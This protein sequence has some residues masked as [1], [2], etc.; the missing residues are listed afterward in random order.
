MHVAKAPAQKRWK[1]LRKR[2]RIIRDFK[3]NKYIY[4]MAVPVLLY[5][6]VIHYIP[7][8]GAVIA[9][10]DFSPVKG[11]SGSPWV[12]WKHFSNFYD[13]YYFWR[14]IRNTFLINVYQLLF[15]FPA[16]IIFALMLN[17][18][19]RQWFKR[20]VQTVTY[21]PHFISIIVVCGM[22]VDFLA[23]DGF[24]THVLVWFGLE[25]TA[26]LSKAEYFR[27]IYIASDIWQHIGWGSII[28]L[29]ALSGINPELYEASKV[30]GAGRF[31]Q[32]VHVTI[33]GI[34]PMIVILLI[35][36]I[37][38][39]MELG[40]EKI[41][42]LYNPN[43]YET[44]DVLASFI[45]RRGL[46]SGSEYSYTTAIGLFQSMIN[47]MLLVMANYISRRLN[48]TSLW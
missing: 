13:S 29:A 41:I 30:D 36:K 14:L 34:M 31:K 39:M 10:K 24:I 20:T 38:N 12:G 3:I 35:L 44:A 7:M 26:L 37:G 6:L 17:E 40:Y 9:F 1:A 43:T 4:I 11:V 15:A 33:P 46:E 42:L 19:S 48:D 16:P 47:F 21:L 2:N 22:L 23:R 27:T 32:V 25:Q 45:Y 28:Y 5:Y 8:Y 18:I